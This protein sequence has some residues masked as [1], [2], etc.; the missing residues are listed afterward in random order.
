[1]YSKR[2]KKMNSR[3]AEDAICAKCG[4]KNFRTSPQ[5]CKCKSEVICNI[6][7]PQCQWRC[8]K[9][10]LYIYVDNLNLLT[11]KSSARTIVDCQRTTICVTMPQLQ[12]AKNAAKELIQF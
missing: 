10:K 2:A 11:F 5:F 4:S 6:C 12:R 9:V 1:M 8:E 7:G 3:S